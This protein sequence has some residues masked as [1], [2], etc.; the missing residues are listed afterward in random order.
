M[1][2]LRPILLLLA[3]TDDAA[4]SMS[5]LDTVHRG[6]LIGYLI[7]LLSVLALTLIVMHFVQIRRVALLPPHHLEVIDDLLARQDVNGALE[8][9][10][11]P[12]NDSYLTRILASGLTRFQRSAFGAFEVKNAIEEAGEDQTARLYRA[13]DA[14]GVIGAIAPL[15]GLLGT[16]L[17]MVG[18]F[19]SLSRSA[20]S[21]HEELA[22]NISLA[23]VT[24]LMGLI[25]AIPCIALFTFF[26]NRI[27]AIGSEAAMEIERLVLYLETAGPTPPAN[28]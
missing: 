3:Q 26:R 8:Y 1:T 28:A 15:L 21:N 14:L 16:V 6:G 27:D 23:L 4:G 17:G 11:S 20:G 12:E 22:S 7:L 5:W 24:T 19:E 2:P 25:L 13:T 10:V 9:C 18:A